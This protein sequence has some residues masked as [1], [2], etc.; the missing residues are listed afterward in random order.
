MNR[1][2]NDAGRT[3]AAQRKIISAFLEDGIQPAIKDGQDKTVL[4]WAKNDWIR[5]MLADGKV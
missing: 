5:Q 2:V 3:K 1:F 4:A